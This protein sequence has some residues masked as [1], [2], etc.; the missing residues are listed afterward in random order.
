LPKETQNIFLTATKIK[1][2]C[3]DFSFSK[4][5]ETDE[6]NRH[7]SPLQ[8]DFRA[9]SSFFGKQFSANVKN[10]KYKDVYGVVHKAFAPAIVGMSGQI[11]ANFLR[12][13]WVLADKQKRSYYENMGKEDQIGTEAFQWARA[14]VFNY[15]K[16]SVGRAIAK[17]I[18]ESRDKDATSSMR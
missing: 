6:Q 17:P 15:N 14:K 11:H 9:K 16:T 1:R 12:L 10:N 7:C 13:L 4:L 3:I 18:L 5:G 8:L 2:I